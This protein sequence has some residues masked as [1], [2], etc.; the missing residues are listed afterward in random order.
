MENNEQQAV[1]SKILNF[2]AAAYE[3]IGG[4]LVSGAVVAWGAKLFMKDKFP[5][6]TENFKSLFLG[7]GKWVMGGLA[8]LN[9]VVN[10]SVR[11]ANA[12]QVVSLMND[13]IAMRSQMNQTGQILNH[14]AGQIQQGELKDSE[15]TVSDAA[16]PSHVAKLEATNAHHALAD[17]EANHGGHATYEKPH[18][19]H[20]EAIAEQRA[21]TA[22]AAPTIH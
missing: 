20:A 7:K 13:N 22:E 19:S 10:Y 9:T 18:G 17:A 12:R 8:V 14:V 15:L 1:G 4:T 6:F 5:S 16:P 11:A 21:H 3:G 2:L